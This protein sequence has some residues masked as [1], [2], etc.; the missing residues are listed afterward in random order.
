MTSNIAIRGAKTFSVVPAGSNTHMKVTCDWP[1]PG[2]TEGNWLPD[3]RTITKDGFTAEWSVP[4]SGI[5]ASNDKQYRDFIG[6]KYIDPVDLYRKLDRSVTYGFLFI[7]V[8]FLIFFL[9]E[10]FAKI[11]FHPVQYLLSGAACVIFFLLLLALSEHIP[12][13]ASYIISAGAVS[14]LVT[15]YIGAITKKIK[16]GFTMIPMFAILYSYLYISL[17][18]EDY[19]LLIGA[20]FAFIV[21][22][23]VMICTRKVDWSALGHKNET[24]LKNMEYSIDKK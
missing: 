6:F 4:F 18:S 11:S 24:E 19:A 15:L 23:V 10:I 13:G 2:F 21:L 14:L 1:S 9:F 20:I 5:D 7:I 3:S 8:P 22:G 16:L 12:F 17:Q